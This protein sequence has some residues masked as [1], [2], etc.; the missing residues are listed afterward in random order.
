MEGPEESGGIEGRREGDVPRTERTAA[1]LVN[2]ILI[3]YM[4]VAWCL[5]SISMYL[6]S[7]EVV[8][9]FTRV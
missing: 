3:V 9:C 7:L 1:V 2:F 5:V 4:V 8:V 6:I